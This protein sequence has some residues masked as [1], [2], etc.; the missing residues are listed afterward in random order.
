MKQ[1]PLGL[2]NGSGAAH[3]S[4][5]LLRTS[6][7]WFAVGVLV[8]LVNASIAVWSF[9][10]IDAADYWVAHTHV[11]IE[12]SQ[13][14]Q[15]DM[16]TADAPARAYLLQPSVTARTAFNEAVR[17][18][19]GQ[20]AKLR[21]VTGDNSLQQQRLAE[22][23]PLLRERIADLSAE[24]DL[25]DK[26]GLAAAEKLREQ[27]LKKRLSPQ[28]QGTC[29]SIEADERRLLAEREDVRHTRKNEALAGMVVSSVLILIALLIG[30]M[31]VG[32]STKKLIEADRSLEASAD[33]LRR[34]TGRLITSQE[35]E[36]RRIA[37]DLHDDLSQNLAYLAIDL[38]RLAEGS[39]EPGVQERL[40]R[41]KKKAGE[42]ADVVRAISHELHASTLDDL[43]L[44]VALEELCAEFEHRTEIR[45]S[46][47][48]RNGADEISNAVSRCVFFV[49]AESLRN[50]GKHSGASTATV[51]VEGDASLLRATIVDDGVGFDAK[52]PREHSGI[53]LTTMRERLY[54]VDG[55]ISIRRGEERGVVVEIVVPRDDLV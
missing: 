29:E 20:F 6:R 37:R 8:L 9:R 1:N 18:V 39:A 43:G 16:R 4:A 21:S 2:G 22:L 51:N 11:V 30:P 52:S 17:A 10:E 47:E 12:E 23:E 28:I 53:G 36:R 32:A 34:L 19:P 50:I 15:F 41:L 33:E 40:L 7:V 26:S 54:L 24:M 25:R 55:T 35:D 49:V 38:G 45:T 46:L 27:N 14:L 13:Q 44:A 5:H 31:E 48:F 42:T 3:H